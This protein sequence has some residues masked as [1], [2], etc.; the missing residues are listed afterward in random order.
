MDKSKCLPVHNEYTLHKHRKIFQYS[1]RDF[2]LSIYNVNS[3]LY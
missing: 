1:I 3:N 2:Y